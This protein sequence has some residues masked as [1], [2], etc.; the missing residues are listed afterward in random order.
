MFIKREKKSIYENLI[1]VFASNNYKKNYRIV[2]CFRS[3]FF[4]KNG[5]HWRY[6]IL[7]KNIFSAVI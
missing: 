5:T 4:Y 1:T 3:W 7:Y 6:F 2:Y